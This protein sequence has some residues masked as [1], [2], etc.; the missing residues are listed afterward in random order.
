M[1]KLN[2]LDKMSLKQLMTLQERIAVTI[3]EKRVSE[4]S[5]LKRKLEMMAAQSGFDVADLFSARRGRR[6]AA[7]LPGTAKAA[8]AAKAAEVI[9]KFRNPKDSSQ[10][11]TGRGRKPNWLVEA[12]GKGKKIDSFRVA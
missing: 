10:T 6:P 11:W 12:L 8:K 3:A 1:A 7:A 2:G 5:D 9:V 4:K